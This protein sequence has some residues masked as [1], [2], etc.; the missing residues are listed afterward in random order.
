MHLR[1]PS[2]Y[3]AEGHKTFLFSHTMPDGSAGYVYLM[4]SGPREMAMKASMQRGEIP[5]YATVIACGRGQPDERMRF[6][7]ERYY[8]HIHELLEAA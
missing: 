5:D 3:L 6:N 2:A 1:T 7:M 8:G 4:C